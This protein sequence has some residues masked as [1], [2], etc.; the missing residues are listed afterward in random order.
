MTDFC[1]LVI[2]DDDARFAEIHISIVRWFGGCV[3]GHH[4]WGGDS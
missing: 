1:K 4:S 3:R 2:L